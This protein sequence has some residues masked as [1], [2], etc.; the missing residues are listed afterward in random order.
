[1]MK[2][3][4]LSATVPV[5]GSY[6]VV[7]AGGG[8]AGCMAAIAAARHGA[9]VALV[10][11]YGFLGG[12]ATAAYVLPL[13]VFSYNGQPTTGGIP[14]EFIQRLDR[15]GGACIEQPLHNVAFDPELYKLCMQRMVR[16][17]GIAL[18]MNSYVTQVESE[19][20]TIKAVVFANKNGLEA[21]EG[22]R[23]I[24][25]TGDADIAAAAGVPMQ[26]WTKRYPLQPASYCFLLNGVDT[27]SHLVK[28]AMHH[29]L[30]GVNC[31]CLPVREKLLELSRTMKL[32]LFGGPWF[33]TTTH[34]GSVMVNMT[35]AEA[36]EC[37]NRAFTDA[38]DRMREEIFLFAD[39]LKRQFREF[40]HSYVAATAVQA[41]H[42]QSRNIVGL[43]TITGEEYL[44]GV[45]YPD[46]VSRCAHPID[47]HTADGARQTCTFIK[48]AAY[49][50]YR[51]LVPA[52]FPNL[53][54]AGRPV[55]ADRTAFASLRVQSSCMGMGQAVGVAATQSLDEKL[56]VQ[57]IDAVRLVKEL[58]RMGA[59]LD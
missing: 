48:Q 56:P 25:A 23:F 17:E 33:C 54:V 1:M 8:P 35:R 31:H 50:P 24:D 21:V 11:R 27:K 20:R 52:D 45:K 13:S 42:R 30:Q 15:M 40:R 22:K 5:V 46:S 2:N 55:S 38:Q 10:E 34:E 53:L 14:W 26:E 59:V 37:D 28:K 43:H 19:E 3:I 36:D 51:A 29:H 47:I 57:K 18:Y 58:K 41:G 32:P 16:E 6:D 44:A 7:V 49:V 12:M 39:L 4:T 9:K